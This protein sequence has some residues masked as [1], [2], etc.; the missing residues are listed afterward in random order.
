MNTLCFRNRDIETPASRKED[1]PGGEGSF[2][3][4]LRE[5]KRVYHVWKKGQVTQEM[6]KDVIRSYRKKIRGKI[7]V[8]TESDDLCKR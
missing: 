7:S 8:R 5:N 6:F 2:S 4:E 1:W 3:Q